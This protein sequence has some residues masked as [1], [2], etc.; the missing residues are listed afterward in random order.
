MQNSDDREDVR[1]PEI[2]VMG[3]GGW[4]GEVSVWLMYV[5]TSSVQN[6][7]RKTSRPRWVSVTVEAA[8]ESRA[9]SSEDRGTD[10]RSWRVRFVVVLIGALVIA[11]WKCVYV[12]GW[13]RKHQDGVNLTLVCL[14]LC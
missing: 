2:F 4:G 8:A 13:H 9:G 12:I 11:L 5:R 10:V 14:C 1:W 6:Q 7:C 3:D